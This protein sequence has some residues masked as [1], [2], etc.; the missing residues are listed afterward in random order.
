MTKDG[1][2]KDAKIEDLLF[3]SKTKSSMLQ[4]QTLEGGARF[5]VDV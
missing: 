4:K 2:A 3:A 5:H 1:C